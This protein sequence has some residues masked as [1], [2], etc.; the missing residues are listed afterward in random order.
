MGSLP[1]LRE[2]PVTELLQFGSASAFQN[3]ATLELAT[4]QP[5]SQPSIAPALLRVDRAHGNLGLDMA[6][7]QVLKNHRLSW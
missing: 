1:I 6:R 7:P 2:N 5:S 3:P 4:P